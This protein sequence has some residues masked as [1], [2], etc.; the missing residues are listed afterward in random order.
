MNTMGKRG[1]NI[2]CDL[3]LEHLNR[4]LKGI[5]KTRGSNKVNPT[6]IIRAGRT[7]SVVHRICQVFQ[8]ETIGEKKA[9]RHPYPSFLKDLK[10]V[11]SVLKDEKI[12]MPI[13]QRCHPRKRGLF[14]ECTTENLKKV[15]TSID[16]L[17]HN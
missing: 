14:Q 5:I 7:V 8:K 17:L 15:Q 11:L 16:Q 12:F 13:A 3:H 10:L 6:S 2:P 4:T 1:E 9:T